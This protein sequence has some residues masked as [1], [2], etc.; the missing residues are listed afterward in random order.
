MQYEDD[1]KDNPERVTLAA[2]NNDTINTTNSFDDTKE[3]NV[4]Y[5]L[6]AGG[7]AGSASVIVGHP[8]DTIKVRLQTSSTSLSSSASGGLISLFR[9]MAA[10]LSTAAVVN[11]IIF[12]AYGASSRWWD[13]HVSP[14]NEELQHDPWK[15]AFVCGT[16]A[17]LCQ[18]F[19]ICPMEHLKCRLQVEPSPGSVAFRGPKDAALAIMRSH[20]ITG[21]YRGFGCTLVREVPAFGAY[22]SVYD[23]VKDIANKYFDSHGSSSEQHRWVCSAFAGGVSGSFTWIMIYPIDVIKTRI[24]TAPLDKPRTN[25]WSLGRSLVAEH[26]WR[27]MFRGLGV[28]LVRAFP[29]NGIIFP[30]YEFTLTHLTNLDR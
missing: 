14:P 1:R 22:F 25:M 21:L 8:F 10:P 15:K 19:V 30:V 3:V 4:L 27:Y 29:V 18:A 17:G 6:I 9:G 2:G 7:V 28:T 23:A 24:Q 13:Q 12:A 11:A 26:G 5:D 20:G 16:Y